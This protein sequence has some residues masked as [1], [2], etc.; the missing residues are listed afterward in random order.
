M[1]GHFTI[2]CMKGLICHIE[3]FERFP[4]WHLFKANNKN[5]RTL[6]EIC[7]NLSIRAPFRTTSLTVSLLLAVSRFHKLFWYFQCCLQISILPSGFR[8][9]RN[10]GICIVYLQTNRNSHWSRF[11]NKAVLKNFANVC[12]GLLLNKD[13]TLETA[14]SLS[15][16]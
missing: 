10:I 15:K 1:F 9:Q 12:G 8:S 4:D 14:D 7:S 6:S 16:L 11:V 3:I 2:L 5:T 13:G